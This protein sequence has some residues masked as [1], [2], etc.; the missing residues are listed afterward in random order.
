[1]SKSRVEMTAEEWMQLINKEGTALPS[2][3]ANISYFRDCI[4]DVARNDGEIHNWEQRDILKAYNWCVD[5]HEEIGDNP[6]IQKFISQVEEISELRAEDIGHESNK[7]ELQN[8]PI[9]EKL[10]LLQNLLTQIGGI[11]ERMKTF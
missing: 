11:I 7:A 3:C 9:G 10:A 1:M 6:I 2:C 8:L 5:S 4:I